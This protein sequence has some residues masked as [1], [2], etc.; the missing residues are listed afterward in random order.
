MG[1]APFQEFRLNGAATVRER[2]SEEWPRQQAPIQCA[3][4]KADGAENLLSGGL[5]PYFSHGVQSSAIVTAIQRVRPSFGSASAS[6]V[7][8][9][10]VAVMEIN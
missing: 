4:G 7:A 3:R 2:S 8:A 5:T 6:A 9:H 10:P 1:R